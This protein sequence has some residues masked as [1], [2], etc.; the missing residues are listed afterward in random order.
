MSTAPNWFACCICL[1][2]STE[3]AE[4]WCAHSVFSMCAMAIQCIKVLRLCCAMKCVDKF[5]LWKNCIFVPQNATAAAPGDNYTESIWSTINDIIIFFIFF[6]NI[7]LVNIG[8]HLPTSIG[9]YINLIRRTTQT[10][11]IPSSATHFDYMPAKMRIS[12]IDWTHQ[13][14]RLVGC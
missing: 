1:V 13:P 9:S 8:L 5:I 12:I 11:E 6:F 4:K 7:I 14:K 2:L 3:A 10:V